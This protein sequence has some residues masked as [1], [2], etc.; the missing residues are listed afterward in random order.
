MGLAGQRIYTMNN[1]R[2]LMGTHVTVTKVYQRDRR[3]GR[4]KW[5]I[6]DCEPSAGWIVGFRTIYDGYVDWDTGEYG[7]KE[8][9]NYF[10]PTGHH[11][12]VLVSFSPRQNPVNVPIDGF[13][14]EESK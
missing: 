9:G 8:S 12:A 4:R 2:A 3:G 6:T 10:V 13:Y 7:Q 5:L 11:A 1:E 14:T